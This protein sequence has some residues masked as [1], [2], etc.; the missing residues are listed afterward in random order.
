MTGR[1]WLIS[2]GVALTLVVGRV[3][4]AAPTSQPR[5]AI[6]QGKDGKLIY[7]PDEHGD[8]IPDFSYCGYMSGGE[9]PNVPVR[10]VIPPVTGDETAR[11]QAAIDYVATLAPDDHGIRG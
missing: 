11:I 10:V 8:R 4:A 1:A 3:I 6:S 2:I 7:A 5:P 9:I